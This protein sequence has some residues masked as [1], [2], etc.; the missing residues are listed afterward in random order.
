MGS[1]AMTGELSLT[2][3]SRAGPRGGIKEKVIAATARGRRARLCLPDEN[4]RD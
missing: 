4:K 3:A 1:A 2:G